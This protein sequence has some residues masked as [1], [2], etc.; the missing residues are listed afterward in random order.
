M[1]PDQWLCVLGGFCAGV[2]FMVMIDLIGGGRPPQNI[3]IGD[4]G[5][6]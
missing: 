2:A 6:P 4:R 1:M 5:R 3:E